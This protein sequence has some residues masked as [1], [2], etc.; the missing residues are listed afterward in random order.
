MKGV[1]LTAVS[2]LFQK[3]PGGKELF[4]DVLRKAAQAFLNGKKVEAA[5]VL[6]KKIWD[7]SLQKHLSNIIMPYMCKGSTVGPRRFFRETIN[8]CKRLGMALSPKSFTYAVT[9]ESWDPDDQT[10]ASGKDGGR[11]KFTFFYVRANAT[12]W[13][14]GYEKSTRPPVKK[15]WKKW[16]KTSKGKGSTFY[17]AALHLKMR[18]NRS[19]PFTPNEDGGYDGLDDPECAAKF[20]INID[21]CRTCCCKEG[22]IRSGIKSELVT[23]NGPYC[24][25]WFNSV[26]DMLTRAW[27]SLYRSFISLQTL[28][29]TCF[30]RQWCRGCPGQKGNK[31]Y[32][33]ICKDLI[34]KD[35]KGDDIKCEKQILPSCKSNTKGA[36]QVGESSTARQGRRGGGALFAQSA[37]TVGTSNRAGNSERTLR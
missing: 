7:Y 18:K 2:K 6:V 10:K 24:R 27:A 30:T 12:W 33:K 25:T 5:R 21:K 23:E 32:Q 31:N 17:Y 19:T 16:K 34:S 11:H 22:L 3:V 20:V 13:R 29:T 37:F 14:E 35:P 8:R 9:D 28:G 36:N 26:P 15:V 4:D 1:A